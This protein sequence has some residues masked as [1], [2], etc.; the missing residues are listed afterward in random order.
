MSYWHNLD[1]DGVRNGYKQT[2]IGRDGQLVVSSRPGR[3]IGVSHGYQSKMLLRPAAARRMAGALLA[4]ANN[5]DRLAS[6]G[7][8]GDES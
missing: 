1:P 2:H 5:A 8:K 4:A 7:G 6:S 3:D